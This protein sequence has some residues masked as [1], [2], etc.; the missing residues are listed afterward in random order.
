MPDTTLQFLTKLAQAFDEDRLFAMAQHFIYP[1]PVYVHD[2]L[3][4]FG[5]PETIVEAL[6]EYR[7]IADAS[8]VKR[9]VPR[10]IAEGVRI[11][12][13]S[14]LWVEWDHLDHSGTCVRTSLV[15][16]VLHHA[17][18]AQCPRIELVDYHVPAFPELAQSLPVARF[19]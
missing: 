1:V 12:G 6:A 3:L 8:G 11:K 5:A 18:C 19:G 2:G 15:Q 14:N 10:I 13:S 16:Y 7:Q 9:I 4:V 17:C